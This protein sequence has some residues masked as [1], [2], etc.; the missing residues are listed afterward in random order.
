MGVW[1]F[2]YFTLF[3]SAGVDVVM[4]IE[5]EER[6]GEVPM[7]CDWTSCAI[8]FLDQLLLMVDY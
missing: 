1:S 3:I 7:D 2:F 4:I 8:I 6:K 5:P